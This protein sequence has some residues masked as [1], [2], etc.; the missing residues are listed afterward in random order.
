MVCGVV[1]LPPLFLLGWHHLSLVVVSILLGTISNNLEQPMMHHAVEPTEART[2]SLLLMNCLFP[3]VTS[4]MSNRLSSLVCLFLSLSLVSVVTARLILLS[5]H[6]HNSSVSVCVSTSPL[7]LM[8]MTLLVGSDLLMVTLFGMTVQLWKHSNGVLFLLLDEVDL[9][10]NKIMCLQ[11]LLEGKGVYLKKTNEYVKPAAGF[12]VV[13]TANTKG[14]GDDTGMFIGAN[15]LNEAFLERFAFTFEQDYPT[16]SVERKIL[17]LL[18]WPAG[19]QGLDWWPVGSL[20]SLSP[21]GQRSSVRLMMMVVLILLSPRVALSTLWRHMLSGVTWT[22]LSL[23]TNRFDDDTK[24][25][26]FNSGQTGNTS[27]TPYEEPNH[28][29]NCPE[30]WFRLSCPEPPDGYV[31]LSVQ[32]ESHM[33][34]VCGCCHPPYSYKGGCAHHL[35]LC[36]ASN[37]NVHAPNCTDAQTPWPVCTVSQLFKQ[38]PYSLIKPKDLGYSLLSTYSK[39][40]YGSQVLYWVRTTWRVQWTHRGHTGVFLWWIH[41]LWWAFLVLIQALAEAKLAEMRGEVDDRIRLL[42][43]RVTGSVLCTNIIMDMIRAWQSHLLALWYSMV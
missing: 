40:Y 1:T 9:A 12:N 21:P 15:I 38:N 32:Q 14:K 42:I 39:Y 20:L 29:L 36:Q 4:K 13:A 30:F 10:S 8:K 17:A 25:C 6:V 11:S 19:W 31:G 7:R 5:K 43:E 18:L 26:F 34:W 33:W 16:P 22:K 28:T 3:L 35:G 24:I 27:R 2:L 41:G 23:C 37:G